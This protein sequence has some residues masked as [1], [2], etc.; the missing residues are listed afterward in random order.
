MLIQLNIFDSQNI[1]QTM[2]STLLEAD[3]LPNRLAK[4]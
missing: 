2:L 3:A 4:T 1:W